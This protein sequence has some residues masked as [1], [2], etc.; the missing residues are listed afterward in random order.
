MV[1][2]SFSPERVCPRTPALQFPPPGARLR[3]QYQLEARHTKVCLEFDPYAEED[4]NRSGENYPLPPSEERKVLGVLFD[5]SCSL[6]GHFY[7][8]THRAQV[9]QGVMA[10]VAQTRWG[11]E[12]GVLRMTHSA[13]AVSL[14]QCELIVTG[15][16]LPPDLIG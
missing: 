2:P 11:L 8:L 1:S 6:D 12:S 5:R 7:N 9:R 13:A 4:T 3:G 10:K 15:S 14:I 16:C